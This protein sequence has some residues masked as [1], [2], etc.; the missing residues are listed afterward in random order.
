M[1]LLRLAA[2]DPVRAH[3]LA[4]GLRAS[5]DPAERVTALRVLALTGKELGRLN[6]SLPH[7]HEALSTAVNAGLAYE[8]AQVRS[9]LVALLTARGEVGRALAVAD[10]AAPVLRGMDAAG[11][12]ANRICALAR[13]GRLAEARSYGLRSLAATKE[14]PP[15]L[16]TN[17]G[18][19]LATCGEFEAAEGC[20]SEAAARADRAGL[21]HEA[22]MA[23]ANLAFMA[24]RQGRLAQALSL[25][26]EA[27]P[28]L[29]GLRAA[30]VRLDRAETLVAAG[31][32]AEARS[33]ASGVLSEMSAGGHDGD[34][35]DGLLVLAK[36]ELADG[37][38]A[39]AAETAE[40]ARTLY[41]KQER[42]GWALLAEHLLL[43]ARWA[44]GDRSAVFLHSAVATAE[45]LSSNGWRREAADGRIVAAKLALRLGRPAEALLAQIEPAHL[46]GPA[47]LRADAW[48]TTALGRHQKGDR[49]GAQ[50]AVRSGLRA[51]SAQIAGGMELRVGMAQA[52]AE[53]GEMGLRLARSA[54][55]LLAAEE[56][57]RFLTWR[58]P[59]RAPNPGRSLAESLGDRAFVEF[60]RVGGELHAVV[61]IGGRHRRIGLGRYE[62]VAHEARMM[63]LEVRRVAWRR[64][65]VALAALGRRLE[66][67]I[68]TPLDRSIADRELVLAPTGALHAVPWA[69]LP[70]LQARPTSVVPTAALWLH[71]HNAKPPTSR[72]LLAAGPGLDH[73]GPEIAALARLHPGATVLTGDAAT[74]QAV[75]LELDGA[76]LAHLAA[77]G[78][79]HAREPLRSGL[80]LADGPMPVTAL[81]GLDRPPSRVVLSACDAGRTADNEA[82]LGLA[83][84]F[85]A[86]G[87]TC[88][89]ASVTPVGDETTRTFMTAFHRHLATGLTP[90]RAL[91]ATPR[92]PGVLGFQCFGVG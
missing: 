50:A 54:S 88:V 76:G 62:P 78:T 55:E 20:V 92:T 8:A 89:I 18:L 79:F 77:H 29:T 69:A 30:Q 53:L 38:P 15:G 12:A 60:I 1:T 27:E 74:A 43:R 63:S 9:S 28:D 44:A 45:R 91:A 25:F 90:A 51:L 59:F 82:A 57:R 86:L 64:D 2:T 13:A 19:T 10:A 75:R 34:V 22:A 47:P 39:Q 21:R 33:L 14:T 67:L 41:A 70:S 7:L 11:L 4:D 5:P 87:T 46:D 36:A 80:R 37:D 17:V 35:A 83:A 42:P 66:S 81:D 84:A 52:G 16:L 48:Q 68:L 65:A 56:R 73:A 26:A 24:S 71:A 58:L 23:R 61:V 49:Y 6:E 40:R 85:L 72:T 3:A 31:R 32:A